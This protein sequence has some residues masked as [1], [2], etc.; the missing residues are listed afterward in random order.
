MLKLSV[1][2]QNNLHL[3]F[4]KSLNTTSIILQKSQILTFIIIH[5]FLI[6]VTLDLN[7]FKPHNILL[8][9]PI[10]HHV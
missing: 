1:N 7:R 9:I 5:F 2:E 3:F 10:I 8:N 6:P 4:I